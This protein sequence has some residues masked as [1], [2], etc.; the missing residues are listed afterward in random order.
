MRRYTVGTFIFKNNNATETLKYGESEG[1][2]KSLR[3][4]RLR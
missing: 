3:N 2:I 1:N 4:V